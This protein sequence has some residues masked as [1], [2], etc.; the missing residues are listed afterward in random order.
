[1]NK[2]K[3]METVENLLLEAGGVLDVISGLI[4]KLGGKTAKT[5]DESLL[6]IMSAIEKRTPGIETEKAAEKAFKSAEFKIYREALAQKAYKAN[7]D[8][9]DRILMFGD[10]R[11]LSYGRPKCNEIDRDIILSENKDYKEFIDN[12]IDKY[13]YKYY[14]LERNRRSNNLPTCSLKRRRSTHDIY[15]LTKYYFDNTTFVQV[16]QHLVE[17]VISNDSDRLFTSYCSDVHKYVYYKEDVSTFE[18]HDRPFEYSYNS[19]SS[20]II[21]QEGGINF[22]DIIIYFKDVK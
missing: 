11:N 15:L 13:N 5:A 12:F 2:L 21:R 20:S 3:L 1:M 6:T 16:L 14:T 4:K 7:K 17:R 9:I 22:N 19:N 18:R 8:N 10:S